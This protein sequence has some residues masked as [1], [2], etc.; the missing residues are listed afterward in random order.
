MRSCWLAVLLSLGLLTTT[1]GPVIGAQS[2][3]PAGA[4]PVLLADWWDDVR[5]WFSAQASNRTR[6]VQFAL[7]GMFVALAILYT[8]G[9]RRR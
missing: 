2:P 6:V 4:T 9:K 1:A 5:A 3:S 7:I 8:A